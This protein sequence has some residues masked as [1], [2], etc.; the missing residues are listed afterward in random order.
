[1]EDIGGVFLIVFFIIFIWIIGIA[2]YVYMKKRERAMKQ[3]C[4]N[5]PVSVTNN[6]SSQSDSIS[7]EI[8]DSE[9]VEKVT[10]KFI[11]DYPNYT[12]DDISKYLYSVVN[13]IILGNPQAYFTIQMNGKLKSDNVVR[14][15]GNVNISSAYLLSYAMNNYD[16]IVTVSNTSDTYLFRIHGTVNG[17]G[18]YKVYNYKILKSSIK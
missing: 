7:Y 2:T 15:M 16:A 5:N 11:E 12:K 13:D 18:F 8:K 4:I 14:K 1:M 10:S 3:G 9:Q 17:N 6:Q